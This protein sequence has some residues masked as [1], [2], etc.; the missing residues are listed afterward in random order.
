M[1]LVAFLGVQPKPNKQGKTVKKASDIPLDTPHP[2]TYTRFAAMKW[3]TREPLKAA[4]K[5]AKKKQG[6]KEKGKKAKKAAKPAPKSKK[7]KGKGKA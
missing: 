5:D 3:H 1:R 2:S 4:I 7:G 6:V